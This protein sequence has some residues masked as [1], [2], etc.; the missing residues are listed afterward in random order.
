MNGN[1]NDVICISKE[2]SPL[3]GDDASTFFLQEG[4]LQIRVETM[5]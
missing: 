3:V 1:V 2:Y 4:Q 5:T